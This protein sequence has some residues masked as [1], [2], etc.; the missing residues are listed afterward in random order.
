MF[1]YH[2]RKVQKLV[3]DIQSEMSN[4]KQYRKNKKDRV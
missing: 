4:Q 3:C 2:Q 1:L